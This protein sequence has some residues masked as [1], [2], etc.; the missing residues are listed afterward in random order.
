MSDDQPDPAA[1]EL[2]AKTLQRMLDEGVVK[3]Y[4]ELRASLVRR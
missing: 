1:S 4:A 2:A 3:D